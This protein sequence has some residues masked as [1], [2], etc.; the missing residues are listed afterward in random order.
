MKIPTEEFTDHMLKLNDLY[1]SGKFDEFKKVYKEFD[2]EKELREKPASKESNS[3]CTVC[4]LS[5]QECNCELK[6]DFHFI[7]KKELEEHTLQIIE[8]IKT[9]APEFCSNSK[10]GKHCWHQS[11]LYGMPKCQHS[12]EGRNSQC[13]GIFDVC[14][15]C[16]VRKKGEDNS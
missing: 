11:C 16:D 5:P 12:T 1:A 10:D 7:N 3:I 13:K 6:T 15:Q 9:P 8:E 14:C 2:I 4:N